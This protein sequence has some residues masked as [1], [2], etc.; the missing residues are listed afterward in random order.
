MGLS[1]DPEKDHGEYHEVDHKWRRSLAQE[2]DHDED[3][4]EHHKWRES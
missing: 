4:R 1:L 2:L 3:H